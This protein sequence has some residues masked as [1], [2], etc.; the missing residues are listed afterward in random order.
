MPRYYVCITPFFPTPGSFRGPYVLDQVKAIERNS[1]YKVIVMKP[2][3]IWSMEDDYVYDD[4][5]VYRF[6]DYTIPSNMWPNGLCDWLTSRALVAKLKA[7]GVKIENISVAHAHVTK[8]GAYANYL[9]RLNPRIVSVVQHHGFDVMSVTDGRL[10]KSKIHKLKCIRHGVGICNNADLNIGVS[11]KTLDYVVNQSGIKLKNKYVLYNGVDTSIFKPNTL[12]RQSTGK[13]RVFKIG[14]IGNFWPLKDQITLIKAVEALVKKGVR[15][16]MTFFIGTGATLDKCKNY[17]ETNNLTDYFEFRT[18]VMHEELP[19]F[20][21][22]LDL[23]VLPSYWEAFGCVYTEAFACGVPFIGVK[24]QGIA[25][26]IPDEDV[27][28]WLIDKGD[29]MK[30]ADLIEQYMSSCNKQM[31]L[32]KPWK[33]DELIQNY[34][35]YLRTV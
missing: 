8:Q 32:S 17:V 11:Q 14:C 7:I 33:V 18:E 35:N 27:D 16:V 28:K 23:F 3:P 4:V 26:I 25:E 22:S 21:N 5:I 20:Y 13:E 31:K 10:G 30:L 6:R 2:C 1:G 29:Y 15:P 19:S 9:K 24:E 12:L 34:L